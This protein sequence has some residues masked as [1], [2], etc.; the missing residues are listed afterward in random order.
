M[1]RFKREI[2]LARQVTHPNVCRVFDLFR[3][4]SPIGEETVFISMELLHGKT[5]K[6]CG[7]LRRWSVRHTAGIAFNYADGISPLLPLTT[8]E[9]SIETSSPVMFR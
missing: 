8:L 9:S 3:N 1:V 4:S 7:A 2:H 5:E 6:L